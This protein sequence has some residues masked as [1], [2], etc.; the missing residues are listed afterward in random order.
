[1][2]CSSNLSWQPGKR[3]FELPLQYVQPYYKVN[4]SRLRS[5]PGSK[6]GTIR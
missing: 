4:G 2:R 6:E 3:T 5:L 1:M